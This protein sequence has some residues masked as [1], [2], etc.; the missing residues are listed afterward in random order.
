MIALRHA[1]LLSSVAQPSVSCLPVG[2]STFSH[3]NSSLPPLCSS[4]GTASQL[5]KLSASIA[6]KFSTSLGRITLIFPALFVTTTLA[7]SWA[8]R[9]VD[10]DVLACLALAFEFVFEYMPGS[11]VGVSMVR[12]LL[13]LLSLLSD[14][15][16]TAAPTLLS[17]SVAA[18]R[19]LSLSA[20]F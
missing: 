2:G 18:D 3:K 20:S 11:T 1:M 15:V 14:S 16:A 13:K 9:M 17:D 19:A 5:S 12:R 10:S 6:S 4:A 7:L 8:L